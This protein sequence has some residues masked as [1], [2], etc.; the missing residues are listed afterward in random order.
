MPPKKTSKRPKKPTEQPKARAKKPRP[1]S[2]RNQAFIDYI[3]QYWFPL[4][5]DLMS[6]D[7][8][9]TNALVG[10]LSD[11][12]CPKCGN[13]HCLEI[14]EDAGG[15]ICRKCKKPSTFGAALSGRVR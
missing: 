6:H 1:I 13:D 15:L 9:R 12:S 8:D 5:P 3:R 14:R 4:Y 2:E 11:L 10:I 7:I